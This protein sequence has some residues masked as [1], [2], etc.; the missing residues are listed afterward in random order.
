MLHAG[1]VGKSCGD[2]EE[3][4][5]RAL[6]PGAR[7]IS[8]LVAVCSEACSV[9]CTICW[10]AQRGRWETNCLSGVTVGTVDAGDDIALKVKAS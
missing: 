2:H 5:M 7:V 3:C 6:H 9:G 8:T 10:C 1:P 4:T